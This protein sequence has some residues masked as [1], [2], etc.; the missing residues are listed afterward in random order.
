LVTTLNISVK[1]TLSSG[2]VTFLFTDIEG[3]TKLWE[4][5]PEAMKA[6]LARHDAIL[7]QAVEGN[8][9]HIIKTTGDGIHAVFESAAGGVSATLAAQQALTE[10]TWDEIKP[11]ALRIRMG[12]HTGDAE[13]RAGDYF[14]PTLNRAARLM[15]IAHGGQILLSKT[16]AELADEELPENTTLLDLGEHRLKDLVRP[17]HVFQLT[18]PTLISEF[19]PIKSINSF[20]NNLPI[21]LTSFIGR[22]REL[23]EAKGRLE[24]ARLLTLIGPGGTGKTRLTLQLAADVLPNF[25]D[26]VWFVELAP[27]A[28]PAL[29]LQTIASV[30]GV[31]EQLGMPLIDIVINY[32]RTKK[33]LLIL[34]NCEHLVESCAQLVDQFLHASQT[35]KMIASSRE[36]LGIS[37]ETV[38]RVPSL[39]LPDPDKVTFEALEGYESVQ[40]L[41]ER[42]RAANPKFRLTE[43]NA[44]SIAQICRRLDGIPLALELAAARLTVFSPEQIATRLDDRFKLLTGGSRTALPRQQTLR[45]LIDWSYDML[46]DEERTLFRRLAVFADGWTFEAAEALCPDLDV[47]DLLTQLVNKSLVA[48]DDE[49]SES[50]YRL[51]ETV[52][53]YARDKLL[54]SGEVEHVRNRHLDYFHD[55][56]GRAE[57]NLYT[58][59]AMEWV[60]KLEAERG[61]MRAAIEWGMENNLKAVLEICCALPNFWLRRGME[62]ESRAL[63]KEA[64][65]RTHTLPKLEGQVAHQQ[66]TLLANAWLSLGFLA[67]S[68]G[69]SIPAIDATKKCASL[70]RQLGDKSL[71]AKALG[72]EVS[73]KLVAGGFEETDALLNEGVTAARESGDPFAT[74]MML[75]MF[76]SRMMMTGHD[77]ETAQAYAEQGI[78]LLQQSGNLWGHTMILM[79]MAMVA[80]YRGRFDEARSSFHACLPIFHDMGDRHRVNMVRSEL[81]HMERAEGHYEIALQMYRET[82][83]V[84][85]RLGHR[86]AIAHQME[87]LAFIAKV[88]EKGE[89]AA[90]LF[91]AA[92]A[93]REQIEIQMTVM[94]R[95]EYERE[96]AD[97][98]AGMDE[99]VFAL[100]WANGRAKTMEETISF[101]LEES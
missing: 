56:A 46:T 98:R 64:L 73:A 11:Q 77:L 67:F 100:A 3:S 18:H 59:N 20:P 79:S 45:A 9:G 69:D 71:L 55:L 28:D 26:G 75:G 21:Q 52:R 33:L 74:G 25:A 15:S 84:W 10:E 54:E 50:R 30:L 62:G 83:V 53:Q 2:T 4:G 97:L 93:L 88:H 31:R 63:I 82:I 60:I 24:S 32:L 89:R 68:Q 38:Y 80:K 36:A 91:G 23:R 99:Q 65:S 1:P 19:P 51:L 12:L 66:A 6:V 92:E 49:G 17:E 58:V 13:A 37:G 48:V 42:A 90:I 47:L 94:E 35:I 86:A 72:F 8:G 76:G 81:A 87:C 43:K 95:I 85:Q 70:A 61:N 22:E 27:L 41:V 5:Y 39:S 78:S 16:T 40:L 44:S 57:P 7:R 14:G 34:D 29:I 96:V 101:A